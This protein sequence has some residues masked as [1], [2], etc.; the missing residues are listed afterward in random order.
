MTCYQRELVTEWLIPTPEAEVTG[1]RQW[2]RHTVSCRP[3]RDVEATSDKQCVANGGR[4][5]RGHTHDVA[6]SLGNT[7]DFIVSS[8]VGSFVFL[9]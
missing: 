6:Q 4:L 2:Q 5:G 3:A 8:S 7:F 1:I 9:D